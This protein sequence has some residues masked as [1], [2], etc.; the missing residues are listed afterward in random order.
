MKKLLFIIPLILMLLSSCQKS[1]DGGAVLDYQKNVAAVSGTWNEGGTKSGITLNFDAG[2]TAILRTLTFTSPDTLSGIS[3]TDTGGGITAEAGGVSVP[4]EFALREKILRAARLFSLSEA[5][6]TDISAEEKITSVKGR[7]A[8]EEWEIE[9]GED[10]LPL[11]ISYSSEDLSCIFE[12]EEIIL[13][14]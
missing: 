6:I 11:K 13:N 10:G 2:D 3:L 12:I 1:S 7:N 5:D 14:E 8:S 9:T 4:L